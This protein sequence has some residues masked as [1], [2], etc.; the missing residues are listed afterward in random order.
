M[1][2]WKARSAI[3]RLG[4]CWGRRLRK[5]AAFRLEDWRL[6]AETLVTLLAVQVGMHVVSFPR[7]LAWTRRPGR[8]LDGPLPADRVHH[9]SW[10]VTAVARM[11]HLKCLAQ[12]L[13]LL[14]VLARR[15]VA[16]DLRI[17]VRTGHGQLMAHAWIEWNGH[18]LNDTEDAL[19]P[20]AR[21]D[22]VVG[23]TLHV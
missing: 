12:S 19:E 20:F 2:D 14:R 23:D 6:F 8:G 16:T 5:A 10:L 9:L 1:R 17:G 21:F 11:L 22:R 18:V 7:L 15:G 13:A 3:R 4:R